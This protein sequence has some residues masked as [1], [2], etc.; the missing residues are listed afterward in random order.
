MPNKN[1][2]SLF[3]VYIYVDCILYYFTQLLEKSFC[4]EY[5]ENN[6]SP[7]L[8]QK[9]KKVPQ[10]PNLYEN[11]RILDKTQKFDSTYPILKFSLIV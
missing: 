10:N 6:F 3:F 4:H 9:F 2:Y 8:C 5:F 7:F 1:Q 11:K